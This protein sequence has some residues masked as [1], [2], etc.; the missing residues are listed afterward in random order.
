MSEQLPVNPALLAWARERAGQSVEEA[1][2]KFRRWVDW[3]A[4]TASPTYPQL[5]QLSDA[6]KVPIAVFF[7]PEPPEVPSIN[8]TFRTLP[9]EALNELPSR[10]RMLLR[11][12]KAMQLNLADLT[13]GRNPAERLITNDL[14]FPANVDIAEMAAVVRDYLGVTLDDQMSWR[15]TDDALKAWRTALLEAG[16]FVFK[17]A[18]RLENFSGFCLFDEEFPIIY[19]NNSVTKTRQ[20]FTYF[21]ELAHLIFHTSG[22]D[23]ARDGYIAR[24]VG[25]AR[26]IEI[27]CNSFAGQ[28]L[29]PENAFNQAM[30]G[31]DASE[32][33]AEAL[34]ARFNVSREVIFRRLLDQG[35]VTERDY[36]AAVQRWNDQRNVSRT[37][38]GNQYWNTLAYLGREYVALA[39]SQYHRNRIDETQLAEFL[40]TKPRY[41]GTL[42]EYY[43]RGT[44]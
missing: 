39:L 27:A 18:F 24:L 40:N 7:F 5:E 13:D 2:Q 14:T 44:A 37:P 33:T 8:E 25:D 38:G 43:S 34:A 28:F 9:E 29:V 11:K 31:R 17:D 26:Q 20:I 22:I 30:T 6:F 32:A 3:E 21:H 35:S 42:E 10:L 16:V 12:A 19:V 41:V 15:T 1:A 23:T 36:D 4:G